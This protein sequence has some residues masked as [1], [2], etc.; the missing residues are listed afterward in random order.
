M[1]SRNAVPAEAHGEATAGEGLPPAPGYTQTIAREHGFEPL[2]VEGRL[3]EG[4]EGTLYRV[5]PALYELFGRPY[6]H[7]FEADGG[8]VAVRFTA[9]KAEGA[10]RVV[11]SAELRMERQRGRPL[12]GTVAPW[13]RRLWNGLRL[14][15]KNAANTSLLAW[16]D[17]LLALYEASRPTRIS[18][19]D[20]GTLGATDLDQTISGGFSAH[21]HAVRARN[22]IYN[23]GLRYGPR[24]FL[25]LYE[26]PRGGHARRIGSLRLPRPVMLH[27]FVAT[28]RHLVFLVAPAEV[29]ILRGLLGLGDFQ[30]LFR[31]KPGN[32]TEV[33]VVPIDDPD[34]A[35][36]FEVDASWQWHFAGGFERGDE[37][38]LD[39][40]RYDDFGTFEHLGERAGGAGGALH[41]TVVSP[42]RR[43]MRSEEIWDRG[44]EFPRIDERRAGGRHRDVFV[45]CQTDGRRGVARVDV[46]RQTDTRWHFDRAQRPSEPLFVPRGPAEGD[47][48]LLTLVYDPPTHRSFVAVL[49][50]ERLSDGPVAQ[51]WFDHHVPMTF[52]GLWWP[53]RA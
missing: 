8:I 10:H 46:D 5:G 29:V 51:V 9:G 45:M 4:L 44:C 24:T 36:R 1:V 49:D 25:N 17:Q 52:H 37:I 32:G 35:T 14:R 2:R 19:E 30:S 26:L 22:A 11:E 15:G 7:P 13:P 31:W 48:W 42:G 41:R 50:A 47:G 3:P 34:D 12:Y 53:A 43:S 38:V 6:S 27:D 39:R 18:P 28:E 16:E 33:I 40:V 23:F 21:P 20:L